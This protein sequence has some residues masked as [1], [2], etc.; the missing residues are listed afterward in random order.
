LPIRQARLPKI[1]FPRLKEIEI[2]DK[3]ITQPK[4][5]I[6]VPLLKGMVTELLRTKR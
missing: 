5:K 3:P 6:T 4:E 1:S 2:I